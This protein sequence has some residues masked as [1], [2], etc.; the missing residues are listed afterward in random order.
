MEEVWADSPAAGSAAGVLWLPDIEAEE[1]RA[2]MEETVSSVL[3]S[4]GL[5]RHF[6]P[7]NR[8]FLK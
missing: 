5:H 7:Q 4:V 8:D 2:G 3:L 6:H 1:K